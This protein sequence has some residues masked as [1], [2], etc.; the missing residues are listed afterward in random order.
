[1]RVKKWPADEEAP[2]GVT[3]TPSFEEQ[4]VRIG[5]IVSLTL[6]NGTLRAAK[7]MSGLLRGDTVVVEFDG[8]RE[9]RPIAMMRRTG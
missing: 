4:P 8:R 5:E 7:V 2:N 1:M 9:E 6:R 3:R